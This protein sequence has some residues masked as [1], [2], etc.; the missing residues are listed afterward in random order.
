[1]VE[2]DHDGRWKPFAEV[3]GVVKDGEATGTLLVHHS[4][5]PPT[6]SLPSSSRLKSAKTAQLRFYV[7]RGEAKQQERAESKPPE[8]TSQPPELKP[9]PRA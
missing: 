7:E 1:V 2:H 3:P 4:V 5:L 6:S 9:T 8:A